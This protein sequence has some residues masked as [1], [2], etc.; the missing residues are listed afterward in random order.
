MIMWM[1]VKKVR[2]NHN[3]LDL[4]IHMVVIWINWIVNN[5]MVRYLIINNKS[6]KYILYF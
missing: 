6:K 2:N 3:L 5:I 1:I 4:N